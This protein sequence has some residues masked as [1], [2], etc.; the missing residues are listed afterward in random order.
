MKRLC[1]FVVLLM[2]TIGLSLKA[3]TDVTQ[4]RPGVTVSGITYCLPK[5]AVRIVVT[6]ERTIFTPGELNNYAERYLRLEDV[7]KQSETVWR[8]TDVSIQPYGIPDT[9]KIYT[10]ALKP[11]TIAPFVSLASDGRLLAIRDEASVPAMQPLPEGTSINAAPTPRQYFTQEMLTATSK[12]KLSELIAQEIFDIRDSYKA[13]T[14]GEAENTPKDGKQLELMLNSLRDQESA[15]TSM[16]AGY[17]QTSTHVYTFSVLPQ[18]FTGKM[19]VARFSHQIGLLDVSNLAGAPLYLNIRQLETFPPEES[20][21]AT[22]KKRAKMQQGVYYNLPLRAEL[23][24]SDAQNVYTQ[25][26]TPL[27]QMGRV[28][29]LSDELFNKNVTT[30]VIFCPLTGGI[31]RIAEQ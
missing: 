18:A 2:M 7:R 3:Q 6:A 8:I 9:S 12:A 11:K 5:T 21:P 27:A 14:R 4:F 16:F 10:I 17:S 31:T 28:E 22:N 26:E 13:L 1:Q 24:I 23:S 29:I 19:M 15:L 25:L 20:D 30:R